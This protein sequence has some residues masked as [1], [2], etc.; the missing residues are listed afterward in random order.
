VN[1]SHIEKLYIEAAT[2]FREL[3]GKDGDGACICRCGTV[4]MYIPYD[5]PMTDTWVWDSPEWHNRRTLDANLAVA[6][7][8]ESWRERLEKEYK[9]QFHIGNCV[10][11]CWR[12][13]G[14]KLQQLWANGQFVESAEPA[15]DSHIFLSLAEAIV[16]AVK[17]LAAEKRAK[18]KAEVPPA[19][20]FAITGEW[21]DPGTT[22]DDR[23]RQIVRE[24][25]KVWIAEVTPKPR[26]PNKGAAK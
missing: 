19:A 11:E 2:Y 12:V 4:W 26:N 5:D 18:A 20:G 15:R 13:K 9:V 21:P 10:V 16:A 22:M 17:A 23:I 14:G 25:L 3:L 6:A 7:M 24:E 1:T 8:T